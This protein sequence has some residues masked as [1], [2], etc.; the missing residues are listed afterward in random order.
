MKLPEEPKA[1]LRAGNNYDS[2]LKAGRF[3]KS[4]QRKRLIL[5]LF[6]LFVRLLLIL[7]LSVL[8]VAVGAS[9]VRTYGNFCK[10]FV[11]F[12]VLEEILD[13]SLQFV[14]LIVVYIVQYTQRRGN[15]TQQLYDSP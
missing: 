1:I 8:S 14:A 7:K 9:A 10:E 15:F 13:S 4:S 12:V 6:F 11:F 5:F 2:F 3:K